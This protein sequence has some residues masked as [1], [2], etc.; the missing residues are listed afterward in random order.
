MPAYEFGTKKELLSKT[1]VV[2]D[3]AVSGTKSSVPQASYS[4]QRQL[5]RQQASY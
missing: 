1:A 4:N 3:I 2:G 5:R